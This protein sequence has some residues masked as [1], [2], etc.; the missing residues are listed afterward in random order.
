MGIS[1]A[2]FR[3]IFPR[4]VG[5]AVRAEI[6]LQSR[7]EWQDGAVLEVNV[8]PELIRRIALLRLPYVNIRFVFQGFSETRRSEFMRRFDRAFQKGGG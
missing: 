2:D 1:H 8:S 6:D 3:R 5:D 4:V 7:V